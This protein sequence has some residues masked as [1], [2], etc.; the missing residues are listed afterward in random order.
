MPEPWK[1]TRVKAGVY[2]LIVQGEHLADIRHAPWGACPW[3]IWYG[4]REERWRRFE[5]F[6]TLKEVRGWIGEHLEQLAKGEA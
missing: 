4:M 6:F 3:R 1:L 2:C 5:D